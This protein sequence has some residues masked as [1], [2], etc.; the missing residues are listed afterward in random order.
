VE[1]IEYIDLLMILLHLQAIFSIELFFVI[2]G[3]I[4]LHFFSI[5][6]WNKSLHNLFE[7]QKMGIQNI[8]VRD[9]AIPTFGGILLIATICI[10][11]F[12]QSNNS[13][14]ILLYSMVVFSLPMII[15]SVAEDFYFNIKP[16]VRFLSIIFSALL[17]LNFVAIEF[18]VIQIPH[19]ENLINSN[20]FVKYIFFS[21]ALTLI[22]NGVNLIDGANGLA[23]LS[24][25]SALVALSFISLH[26]NDALVFTVSIL[27]LLLLT[28]FIFFNYPMG[29]I[30]LGDTGAYWLGWSIG[31][32]IIVFYGR[33]PEIS[34]WGAILIGFYPC[35]EVI[36]SFFRKILIGINP[37]YPDPNHIHLKLFF[38]LRRKFKNNFL[39]NNLVLPILSPLWFLPPILALNFYNDITSIIICICACVFL[40][41][42]I[43]IILSKVKA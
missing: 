5:L 3:S 7:K 26:S 18:P 38:L 28:V 21:F 40:Y 35:M 14:S 9:V 24:S 27:I 11:I 37:F 36:F 32:L 23:P 19:I 33:N 17:F 29:I 12:I 10:I 20:A 4:F 15:F 42:S 30:F 41:I 8:H 31:I 25:L 1:I 13:V 6:F 2:L 39:A 22:I 34:S 43:F 16:M